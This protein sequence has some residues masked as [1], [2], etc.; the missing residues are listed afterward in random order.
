MERIIPCNEIKN[1]D[2]TQIESP[3]FA[4]STVSDA[5][6]HPWSLS[7][8]SELIR[9]CNSSSSCCVD[10]DDRRRILE[11]IERGDWLLVSSRPFSPL[12]E[13]TLGKYSHLTGRS[14]VPSGFF[15][16]RPRSEEYE[17]GP[18]RWAIIKIDYD[19]VKNTVAMLANRLGSLGDEGRLFGSDGKDY[20]NTTRVLTQQWVPLDDSD[21]HLSSRSARYRYGELRHIKQSYQEGRINGKLAVS[22]GIG[23]L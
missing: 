6:S 17:V 19:G 23:S 3:F 5:F 13:D 20:S 11:K 12:S 4:T 15:A 8:L 14:F 21:D 10:P 2:L 9:E 16:G 7:G 1:Y 22:R 18:G